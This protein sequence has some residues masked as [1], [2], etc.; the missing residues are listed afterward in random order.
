MSK[1]KSNSPMRGA[2]LVLAAFAFIIIIIYVFFIM[3]D[4]DLHSGDTGGTSEM[5]SFTPGAG[6]PVPDTQE[7]EPLSA[8]PM[9]GLS[10]QVSALSVAETGDVIFVA[11]ATGEGAKCDF[12]AFQ[13][14][15]GR[16]T[17]ALET[18]GFIGR[19]GVSYGE[20]QE[21]DYTTPGGV[22]SMGECFGILPAPGKM[23]LDY[24]K[25]DSDCYWDGDNSSETYNQMVRKSQMPEDWDDGASEHLTDYIEQ[26][27]YCMNI[28]F[29][30][31]PAVPGRGFA[32]FLHCTKEGMEQTAG[33]VAI[34]PK[35]MVRCLEMATENTYIVILQDIGDLEN[36]EK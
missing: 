15:G 16:W 27:K 17:V 11:A 25:V 8:T 12:Y 14:D 23:T 13:K 28:G 10:R 35:D 5:T 22:F 26:Y 32:I 6:T 24:T 18:T 34:P 4:P 20:R 19:E 31:D 21:G 36:I 9:P 7:P 33:C 29:N 3:K 2:A 1:K 30:T